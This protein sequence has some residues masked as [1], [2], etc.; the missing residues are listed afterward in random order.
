MNNPETP[1]DPTDQEA[2]T[3]QAPE[4]A[5]NM[6]GKY[7]TPTNDNPHGFRYMLPHAGRP[8]KFSTVIELEKRMEDYFR[9]CMDENGE[10]TKTVTVTGLCNHIG[11]TRKM[12]MEYESGSLE[13]IMEGSE[14][15]AGFRNAIKRAKSLCEQY[16]EHH[17]YHA[18]NP[19]FAIF[20]LKQH[21]WK[22]IQTVET[23]HTETHEVDPAT[24]ELLQGY[25]KHL[26]TAQKQPVI[27]ITPEGQSGGDPK[28]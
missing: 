16:A 11:V 18:R 19:A 26:A 8:R 9:G 20:A 1:T 27:D 28:P 5:N 15:E 14:D 13:T 23:Q 12:L 6:E 3:A 7:L 21:G 22:D 24:R 25:M 10:Y 4:G 2:Q 17:G